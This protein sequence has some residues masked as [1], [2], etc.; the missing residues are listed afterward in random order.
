MFLAQG[1]DQT[2][3][4]PLHILEIGF[5]TGLNALLTL[6]RAAETSRHV[7]YTGIEAFPISAEEASAVDFTAQPGLESLAPYFLPMHQSSSFDFKS[8]HPFFKLRRR[9]QRFEEICDVGAFHLVYFDAFGYRVQPELWSE[10]IFRRMYNALKPGGLLVTYAARSAI[11]HNMQAA[12]FR[13][14]KRPGPIGKREMFV[15]IKEC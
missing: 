5:G 9:L 11:R 14:E 7:Y 10:D 4:N 2:N 12:G 6:Q 3:H 8:L 13:V 1:F 15:A